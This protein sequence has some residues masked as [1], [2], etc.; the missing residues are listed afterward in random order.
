MRVANQDVIV[1]GTSS[2]GVETLKRLVAQLPGDLPAS[3]FVVM[4]VSAMSRSMLPEL[5]SAAGP[6]PAKHAKDGEPIRCGRIYIAPPDYHLVLEQDHV[7]LSRGPKEQHNRPCI[8]IS[9]RS[10]ALAFGERVAGVVLSGELDD[11]TAGLFEIKRRGGVAVI[12]NP[13]EAPFPSMPLSALR[14][15]EADYTVRVDD[16]GRVLCGLAM[17]RGEHRRTQIEVGDMHPKITDL[18]CPDCSG[19]I[20]EVDQG[21]GKEYRCRVGHSFSPRGMLAEHFARQEKTLYEAL[22]SLEEGASLASRVA[23]QF[24]P[25]TGARLREEIRQLQVQAETVRAVLIQRRSFELD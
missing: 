25:E 22:V 18:T 12:Q 5:L 2:G 16:M 23:G 15:V 7:H 3:L 17:G 13:E 8:N 20:W 19:T 1:I 6:I 4:H 21:G 14:E 10:A 9:F 11:G 24:D